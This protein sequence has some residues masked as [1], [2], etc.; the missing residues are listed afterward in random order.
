MS[1]SAIRTTIWFTSKILPATI[2]YPPFTLFLETRSTPA[3]V[4]I[5]NTYNK[6]S[7]WNP[8]CLTNGIDI[9]ECVERE[10]NKVKA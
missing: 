2:T 9:N 10:S 3:E 4:L 1:K 7:N 6:G 5:V 8:T